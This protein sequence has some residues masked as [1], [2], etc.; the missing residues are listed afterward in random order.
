MSFSCPSCG[1]ENTQKISL[2]YQSGTTNVRLG[3]I[4]VGG[5]GTG[6]LGI[7]VGATGGCAQSDLARQYAP[8]KKLDPSTQMGCLIVIGVILTPIMYALTDSKIFAVFVLIIFIAAVAL[9]YNHAERH[10]T[11]VF[12]QQFAEWDKK[13]LCL[14]C[15]VIFNRDK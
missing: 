2:L 4:G 14:R 7:G 13:F 11:K 8:P 9:L 10:N 15:G 1:S 3:S 12:P 5:T 6:H